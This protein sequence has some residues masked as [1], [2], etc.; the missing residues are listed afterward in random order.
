MVYVYF[1]NT[2][3]DTLMVSGL[4]VDKFALEG[5]NSGET[6][7]LNSGDT[8]LFYG[9]CAA[10]S[11]TDSG[12]IPAAFSFIQ[13][14]KQNI[15]CGYVFSSS[16][17]KLGM[18]DVDTPVLE[19][20][21]HAQGAWQEVGE[22]IFS[23]V[24]ESQSPLPTIHFCRNRL[25]QGLPA[26][27]QSVPRI[28]FNPQA[29]NLERG[30]PDALSGYY[31]VITSVCQ[32]VRPGITTALIENTSILSGNFG[33]V[34]RPEDEPLSARELLFVSYGALAQGVKGLEYRIRDTDTPEYIQRVQYLVSQFQLLRPYLAVSARASL[35]AECTS[36]DVNIQGLLCGDKGLIFFVMKKDILNDVPIESI[37][38]SFEAPA[39]LELD[40]YVEVKE[41]PG[42]GKL[43]QN[44]DGTYRMQI[45]Q[46]DAA[47]VILCKGSR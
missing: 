4:S 43:T 32:Y 33:D 38:I 28:K 27:A 30:K 13:N 36:D 31:D 40:A 42:S 47:T 18:D 17:F 7:T 15:E 46:L 37:D 6:L 26:F 9:K 22:K 41:K 21:T 34:V 14:A 29:S 12:Y 11:V 8:G 16:Q 3:P 44:A 10:V 19:C 25:A 2:T 23:A 20:M 35:K 5:G 1:Q 45:Q 24:E 39:F